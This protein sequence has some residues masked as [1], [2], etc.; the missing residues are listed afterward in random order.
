MAKKQNKKAKSYDLTPKN[1]HLS[2]PPRNKIRDRINQLLCPFC[3]RDSSAARMPTCTFGALIQGLSRV[4]SGHG[5]AGL[6]ASPTRLFRSFHMDTSIN[7]LNTFKVYPRR[8]GLSRKKPACQAE[9]KSL[10]AVCRKAFILERATR[11][12]LATHG[13]GSRYSTTELRPHVQLTAVFTIPYLPA[14]F[15][16]KD[17]AV[18]VFP[19]FGLCRGGSISENTVGFRRSICLPEFS[20]RLRFFHRRGGWGGCVR[21]LGAMAEKCRSNLLLYRK[22]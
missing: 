21:R 2:F 1:G 15:K 5:S 3:L 6:G 13:L 8:Q 16:R 9:G 20:G 22:M 18:A 11:F 10:P 4:P 19:S 17:S 12:E 14:K 7:F